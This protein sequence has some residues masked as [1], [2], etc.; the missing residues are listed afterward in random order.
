MDRTAT[1]Y[2]RIEKCNFCMS[3]HEQ[4]PLF[5]R[6]C[7]ASGYLEVLAGEDTLD[8]CDMRRTFGGSINVKTGLR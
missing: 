5:G 6:H 7:E 3:C 4:T 2:C 1:Y 8:L